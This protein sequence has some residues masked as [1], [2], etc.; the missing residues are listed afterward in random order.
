MDETTTTTSQLHHL[1]PPVTPPFSHH[2]PLTP[3]PP[4]TLDLDP[5][6]SPASGSASSASSGS[7]PRRSLLRIAVSSP[8]KEQEIG[9]SSTYVTY[10][11]TTRSDD[12]DFPIGGSSVRR[13]FRDVVALADRLAGSYRGCFVPARPDKGVVEGQV[14]QRQDFVEQRRSALE[15]YLRRLAAHPAVGRS[16][17]LRLFLTAEGRLPPPTGVDVASRVIDGV[18]WLPRQ[19]FGGGGAAAADSWVA[20][21]EEVTRAAKGGRALM[22]MFKE[23][24][25]SVANEW[26][27]GRLPVAEE[28]KE[29]LE[30]KERIRDLEAQLGNASQKAEAL[31]KAQ[32]HIGQ[33]MGE[34]G[35][36]FIKLTKF[37]N[38][39]AVYNSQRVR[40][41]NTKNVATSAI[42]ASRFYRESN[43]QT[44]KHL[45]ALHDYLGLM[46]S[47]HNAFSDRSS[48]LL[49]VQ[50]LL[51][52]LSSLHSRA[53]KLETS[54]TKV[55]GGDKSRIRKLIEIR[56]TIKVT[57][58]AKIC[59]LREYERIKENNRS[60]LE[61]LDRERREDFLNM[62][63]GFVINQVGYAEKRANV[64]EKVAEETRG[65]TMKK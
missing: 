31:D 49:A 58:D 45:D 57:E 60:E 6:S 25:Q 10:L 2:P 11:I 26:G 47:V 28:E 16:E 52:E 5:P 54:S 21:E 29:F 12:P 30:R 55:F 63:K 1:S 35:L 36:A 51:S 37:E 4:P 20:R 62:L 42:K 50:T 17:E 13:R 14:M 39:E 34:L 65:Y 19:V 9:T 44:V 48:A 27:G 32:Q 64:W 15:R 18:A 22:R 40:A 41:A 38:E 33:T 56:E 23:L 24:R 59:A 43:T 61:R 46:L 53:E 8:K 7:A 3:P